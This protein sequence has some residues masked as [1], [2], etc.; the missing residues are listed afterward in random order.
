M[1]A[2]LAKGWL[3]WGGSAGA[4]STSLQMLTNGGDNEGLFRA[5]FMS[6]GG[7]ISSGDIE[8]GTPGA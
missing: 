1:D 7:P 5:A 2:G 6:S 4:I 8:D 3:S